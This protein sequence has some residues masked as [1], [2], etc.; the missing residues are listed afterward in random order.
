MSQFAFERAPTL[1]RPSQPYA[2]HSS[3]LSTST[4]GTDS[5]GVGS[6]YAPSVYAQS[7]LAASTVMPGMVMQ[8]VRSTETTR[9]VEGHCLQW[10]HYDEKA[11]CSVCEERSD[12]G[13]YRCIGM[14]V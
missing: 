12:D 10:R 9:W 8:P 1:R 2:G 5:R 4:L 13:I 3:S 6:S 7:T 11:T 14:F